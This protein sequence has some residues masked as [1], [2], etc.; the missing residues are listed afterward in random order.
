MPTRPRLPPA[1]QRGVTLIELIVFIVVISLALGAL[2]GV[3]RYSV[4]NSV[5]PVVRVRLIEAA[6]SQLDVVLAQP[7]DAN[8]PAGGVPACGSTVPSGRPSPPSCAD[9]G[10][11]SSFDGYSDSPYSSY[12]RQVNVE[13]A[14]TELGLPNN[15]WAKRI[16][17][18][19]TAPD[20]QSVTL[21]AYR[22]NF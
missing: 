22:T 10:G 20:G 6:Q 14:G 9:A 11:V 2:L 12:Q 17:V 18:I 3:Y 16:T 8:T 19:A 13:L 21:S 7:Y 15:A 4:V 5:D 1:L